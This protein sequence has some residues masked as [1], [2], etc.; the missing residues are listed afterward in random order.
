MKELTQVTDIES[1]TSVDTT[2]SEATVTAAAP[3][4]HPP[5]RASAGA[6]G[7]CERSRRATNTTPS[8]APTRTAG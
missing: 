3:I 8:P 6:N 7:L 4:A 1:L 5:P 2:R